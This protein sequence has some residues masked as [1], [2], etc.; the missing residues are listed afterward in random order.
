M[1]IYFN[2]SCSSFIFLSYLSNCCKW[3]K[4]NKI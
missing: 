3:F 2:Y 1:L 4:L